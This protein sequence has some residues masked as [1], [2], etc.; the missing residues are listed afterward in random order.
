[1]AILIINFITNKTLAI[2]NKAKGRV[3]F[4]RLKF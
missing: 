4:T 1:M 3:T 2:I